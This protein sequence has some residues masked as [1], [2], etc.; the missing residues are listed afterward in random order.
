MLK[1]PA[2]DSVNNT[3]LYDN[4]EELAD[5]LQGVLLKEDLTLIK[6]FVPSVKFLKSTFDTLAI[7]YREDQV[8]YRQ[9]MLM[10]GLQKD[11]H[12]ILKKAKKENINLQKIEV[13][14]IHFE[15]GMDEKDNEF[16]YVTVQGR[17]RKREYQWKYLAIRLI[18][19]WFLG[20]ELSFEEL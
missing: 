5:S 1:N 14:N 7:E 13:K 19:K 10:R 17:R 2:R 15:Y 16:C 4:V 9:Q 18:D 8:I 6:K 11:L 12:K 20:D 3:R